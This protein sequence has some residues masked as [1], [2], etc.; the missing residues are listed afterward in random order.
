MDGPSQLNAVVLGRNPTHEPTM[1]IQYLPSLP[2]HGG[3][4]GT[5]HSAVFTRGINF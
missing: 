5:F 1:K 2:W 3:A 4:S